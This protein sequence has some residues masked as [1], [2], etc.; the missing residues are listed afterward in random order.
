MKR[1]IAQVVA[2]VLLSLC[3]QTIPIEEW[4]MLSK[5]ERKEW[6]SQGIE[7]IKAELQCSNPHIEVD[8]DKQYLYL[9]GECDNGKFI[10][11]AGSREQSRRAMNAKV[12]R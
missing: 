9:Y 4:D 12:M 2:L 8:M 11:T 3:I 5:P 7:I 6:L 1:L 10:A